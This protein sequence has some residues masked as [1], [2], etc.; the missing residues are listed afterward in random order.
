LQFKEIFVIMNTMPCLELSFLG[1]FQVKLDSQPVTSFEA[2]KVRALLAYLAVE[3]DHSHRREGLA[4]LFWPGWPDT[5]ARTSLRNALSNLRKAIGD[6]NV[7]PPF[8]LITRET[9]QFNS[10]SDYYLDTAEIERIARESHATIEQ[11][12]SAIDHYRGSFLEG[13]TL[14]DCPGFDDWE[15]II[16]ERMQQIVS[17]LLFRLAEKYER[18]KDYEKAI[19]D[20]RKRLELEPWQE[21]AHRQLMRLLAASGQ[22]PAALAQFEAC[23][24]SLKAELGVEPE[25]ETVRLYE[26]IRDSRLVELV[27]PKPHPHNLPAQLTSFIGREKEI[28]EIRRLFSHTRLLTLSGVGG[29]GKTRLALEVASGLVEDFE[30]GVW[31]V[32]LARITDPALILPSVAAVF[33]LQQTRGISLE[34]LLHNHLQKKRLLLIL[35]NCEHLISEVALVADSLL[36]ATQE[37]KILATS[38]EA[39]GLTGETIYLVPS[40]EIPDLG[41][42]TSLELLAHCEAV[43]LF[44]ERATSALPAFTLTEA[45]APAII[46]ICQRLD[47]IPLALELAAARIKVLSVEQ[48]ATRLSDRFRL[49][50][51]GSRAA[52]PRQQTLQATIDWSYELLTDLERTLFRRLAVFLG[53]WTLEAA[54]VICACQELD[55][56]KVLDTLA[57]L[58]NKSL[59]MADVRAGQVLRYHLL[60]TIRQYALEKLIESGEAGAVHDRHLA[61]YVGTAEAIED[62]MKTADQ[63][64]AIAQADAEIHNFRAALSWAL[65]DSQNPQP[66]AGLR[67]ANALHIYFWLH[68]FIM[69]DWLDKGLKLLHEDDPEQVNVRAKALFVKG[70]YK[71]Y[72]VD[73]KYYDTMRNRSLLKESIELYRLGGDRTGLGLALVDY[74]MNLFNTPLIYPSPSDFDQAWQALDESESIFRELGDAWGL[75]NALLGKNWFAT[76]QQSDLDSGLRYGQE[77]LKIFRNIGDLLKIADADQNICWLLILKGEYATARTILDESIAVDRALNSKAVYLFNLMFSIILSFIQSDYPQMEK[78]TLE[79]Y[80]VGQEYNDIICL[81]CG[82]RYL[83]VAVLFQAQPERARKLLIESLSLS[84][85]IDDLGGIIMFPILMAGVAVVEGHRQAAARL[86]SAFEAENERMFKPLMFFEQGQYQR[87]RDM[88]RSHLDEASF[89]AERAE[90]RKMTLEQAIAYA[91]EVTGSNI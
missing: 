19:G 34:E 20:V 31:L 75:G 73:L 47:G 82:L 49:L 32:E 21:D 41:Q 7:E 79:F 36:H 65:D 22:R 68:G 91:K 89:E 44:I 24:R 42:R 86:V 29:T 15:R 62:R 38:R 3:S 46:Q 2:D 10:E 30:H 84:Q 13:F 56:H 60:E 87:I 43:R 11:L 33:G 35:D 8:L 16:R 37:I 12:Q 48:I 70:K 81:I 71:G 54:E 85:E 51:S 78:H 55:S 67:L 74:A 53:G 28:A 40:L 1:P 50:T 57:S 58:V 90:G 69:D 39:L 66:L 64:E 18:S 80:K 5:S 61:Y 6:D 9:I 76:M 77:A 83:G 17:G 72:G 4:A 26:S 14:K 52:L 59:V 63:F 88:V 45:N 25:A 27:T 23:K